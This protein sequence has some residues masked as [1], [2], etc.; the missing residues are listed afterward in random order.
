[1]LLGNYEI[2]EKCYQLIRAFDKLNFFYMAQG[3]FG[4]IKK[5]QAVA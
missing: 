5:M 2:A 4:K 3:S 1:M